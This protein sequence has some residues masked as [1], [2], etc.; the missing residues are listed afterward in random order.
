MTL[1]ALSLFISA[2]ISPQPVKSDVWADKVQS[3]FDDP[4]Y[5]KVI[6]PVSLSEIQVSDSRQLLHPEQIT[7]YHLNV[8]CGSRYDLSSC[9]YQ[10]FFL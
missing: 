8:F 4:S 9:L 1:I 6:M 7:Q 10:C 3:L 5:E 2:A